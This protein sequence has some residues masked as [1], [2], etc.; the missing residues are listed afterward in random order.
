M[1]ST[2]NIYLHSIQSVTTFINNTYFNGTRHDNTSYF[3]R[4][5]Y[6]MA[7]ATVINIILNQLAPAFAALASTFERLELP[8]KTLFNFA[9]SRLASSAESKP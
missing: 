5:T 1:F 3:L 7:I 4:T 9:I 6:N 2:I 8:N